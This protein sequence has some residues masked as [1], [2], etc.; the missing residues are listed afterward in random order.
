MVS[1]LKSKKELIE[2]AMTLD[3]GQ[4]YYQLYE[5]AVKY[6]SGI[7]QNRKTKLFF[8]TLI[9]MKNNPGIKQNAVIIGFSGKNSAAVI[10]DWCSY[11]LSHKE[12]ASLDFDELH[13]VMGYC[14]R[15]SKIHKEGC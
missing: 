14:A 11:I 3:T 4:E 5:F 8:D 6:L 2:T 15:L 10:K 9:T 1:E 12:L 13:Y 7:K